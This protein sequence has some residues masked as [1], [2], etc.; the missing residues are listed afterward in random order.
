MD[1]RNN[2]GN[3]KVSI[4]V[5]IY[6]RSHFVAQF[7]E[8]IRRQTYKDYEL[9]VVDDGS[10]EDINSELEK[11]AQGLSYIYIRQENKG[12]YAARNNALKK[13]QG[14]YIAFH[15][16]DDEWP[17]YHLEDFV[18]LLDRHSDIDWVFGSI[19]RIDHI[20][21]ETVSASNYSEQY[22]VHPFLKLDCLQRDEAKLVDDKNI[23]AIAIAHNVPGST[24]CALIRAS[25]FQDNL[26]DESFR[27]AYDRFF[28]MKCTKLG[29]RFAYVD[30]VHQIYHVHDGHISLVAGHTPEKLEAS[31]RTMLRGYHQLESFKLTKGERI[32]LKNK[33]AS[34]YAWELSISYRERSMHRKEFVALFEAFKIRP[35]VYLKPT[36]ASALRYILYRR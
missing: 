29:F 21:G 7:L 2:K 24:Q 15:D 36:L 27:T 26:F 6:N 9:I 1:Y 22:G 33:I 30:K 28:A 5:P 14:R 4:I 11:N 3:P 34:I 31:A 10:D 17:E 12:H 25:V 35:L 8:S 19:K 13:A 23:T 16:S 18:E 20:T 32:A